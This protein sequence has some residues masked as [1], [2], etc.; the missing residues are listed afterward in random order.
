M[1]ESLPS[2][3][4]LQGISP[5]TLGILVSCVLLL[6]LLGLQV[7]KTEIHLIAKLLFYFRFY[8]T[9]TRSWVA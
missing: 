4:L 8:K 5:V 3:S 9:L 7:R 2:S 1:P 6:L